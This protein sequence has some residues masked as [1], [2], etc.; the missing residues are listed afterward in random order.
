VGGACGANGGEN[1]HRLLVGNPEG[2][3]PLGRP[4]RDRIGWC[5]LHWS[6]SG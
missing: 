6:G 5:G 1:M 3:G 4:F 2:K